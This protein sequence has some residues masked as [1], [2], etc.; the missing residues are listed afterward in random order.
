MRTSVERDHPRFVNHFVA[1][2]HPA[3]ALHDLIAGVVADGDHRSD[4]AARDAPIV[5]AEILRAVEHAAAAVVVIQARGDGRRALLSLGRHRRNPAVRR[6]DDERGLPLRPPAFAPVS[7]RSGAG[8]RDD[9]GRRRSRR[10]EFLVVG[11]GLHAAPARPAPRTPRR[12]AGAC[13]QT[14]PAARAA[15][16]SWPSPARVLV[17]RGRP[18][19]C[20]GPP[21]TPCPASA[22]RLRRLS[23][24][25]AG[26][27]RGP[28]HEQ[29]L[30]R[31]ATSK[32][33]V[34][35]CQRPSSSA[36]VYTCVLS[37][38]TFHDLR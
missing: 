26:Q 4:H 25:H 7:G 21:S 13:R 34:G 20:R 12:T 29:R 37:S 15:R 17:D 31:I 5:D 38:S 16:P 33:P 18:T 24:E 1:K 23:H 3:R 27:I 22:L 35:K 32:P 9:R 19:A 10:D 8:A 2:G 14:A 36:P 28:H 30:A 11:R 6:I